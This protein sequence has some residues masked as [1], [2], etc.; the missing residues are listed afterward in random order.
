MEKVELPDGRVVDNY[1]QLE[2]PS[3]AIVF[4]QIE[5]GRVIILEQYKHGIREVGLF[6][7][8]GFIEKD[9]EP[10]IA[11]QRELLEET[12]YVSHSWTPL[13]SFVPNTNYGCGKAHVFRCRQAL[14][15]KEPHSGDLEDSRLILMEPNE[16]LAAIRRGEIPS[17]STVVATTLS[18]L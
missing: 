13:G 14:Q 11:A 8:A 16:L 9:E 6:L 10:L 5:D 18:L 7:P 2:L 4:A 12:G 3:F 15:I 1:H 17:M